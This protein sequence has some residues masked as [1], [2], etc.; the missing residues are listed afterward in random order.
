[1]VKMVL[2]VCGFIGSWFHRFSGFIVV[3]V[4]L[5]HRFPGFI[6]GFTGF[7]VSQ[8][9]CLHVQVSWLHCFCGFIG[10]L[11]SEVSWFSWYYTFHGFIG[12]LASNVSC[13]HRVCGS[14]FPGFIGFLVTQVSW[15]HRL[16]CFLSKKC[17]K[18]YSC[19]I[20]IMQ[21]DHG[22]CNQCVQ[23][24]LRNIKGGNFS[25][26]LNCTTSEAIIT[27]LCSYHRLF[28]CHDYHLHLSN[29]SF[30]KHMKP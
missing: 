22:H 5:F 16:P 10:F 18:I 8:V 3:Q 29:V 7:M 17:S 6:L 2:W 19:E 11:D 26:H 13:F 12:F 14:I 23:K 15:F 30:K 27:S 4:S 28:I 1:M 20:R 24:L 21:K 9:S 25:Y